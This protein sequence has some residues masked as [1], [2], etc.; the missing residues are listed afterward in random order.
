MGSRTKKLRRRAGHDLRVAAGALV[1]KAAKRPLVH[2]A[3]TEL[4]PLRDEIT[5]GGWTVRIG[6]HLHGS[7][8]DA[9][10]HWRLAVR[11]HPPT[12]AERPDEWALL[13][14][15]VARVTELTGYDGPELDPLVPLDAAPTDF[16][17]FVWH[18]DGAPLD[19]EVLITLRRA[20]RIENDFGNDRSP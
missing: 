4:C 14:D 10:E 7:G 1:A 9:P 19:D 11:L 8:E 16:H 3:C 12:R 6:V 2:D 15:F 17:H 18:S 20:A 13:G 5:V